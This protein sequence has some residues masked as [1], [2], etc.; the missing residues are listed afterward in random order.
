MWSRCMPQPWRSSRNNMESPGWKSVCSGFFGGRL[1]SFLIWIDLGELCS[2]IMWTKSWFFMWESIPNWAN[3]F[4]LVKYRNNCYAICSYVSRTKRILQW[5]FDELSTVRSIL[6][7]EEIPNNHLR[8]IKPTI[9]NGI[10]SFQLLTSSGGRCRISEPSTKAIVPMSCRASLAGMQTCHQRCFREEA[11]WLMPQRS[12]KGCEFYDCNA[13]D[14]Q[15]SQNI[16]RMFQSEFMFRMFSVSTFLVCSRQS[17]WHFLCINSIWN[18]R[19]VSA[20]LAAVARK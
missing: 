13:S 15:E 8:C 10:S 4:R 7:M 2:K 14:I 3:H 16:R 6:L 19:Y 5:K 11:P 17:S 1:S 18:D 20:T 12:W 9:N